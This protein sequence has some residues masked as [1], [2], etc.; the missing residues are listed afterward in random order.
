MTSGH[1]LTTERGLS[2]YLTSQSIAYTSVTLLTGGTANYVYRVILPSGSTT[3]YKHA[4]PYLPSNKAFAFDPNRMDY[5]DFVLEILPSLLQEQIPYSSVHA[6]RCN[7]YDPEIKLLCIEDGGYK[8]LKDA[9]TDLRL[10]IQKVGKDLGHWIAAVHTRSTQ[11]SL[12]LSDASDLKANNPTGVTI[13]RHSYRNLAT[14]FSQYGHDVSLA[15][16][17]D[18]EFGSRLA[19]EN[20]CICHGDFWPGNVLVK[21]KNE[22]DEQVDLTIV[23]WEMTRRGISATDVAQFCAEAFLLDRFRGGRELLPTFLNAYLVARQGSVDGSG[24]RIGKEW[25]RRLAVHW[26][27]HV[28]FWPTIVQWTDREGTQMLVDIGARVLRAVVDGDWETMFASA[29]LKGVDERFR[30]EMLRQGSGDVL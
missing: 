3:I 20:E 24:S 22:D 7:F 11:T 25:I 29:L 1:N 14:A 19:T 9:Y 23:D 18:T 27:V 28:A 5:E 8:M 2:A 16:Y 12:S 10:D 4:A 17:I 15:E 21:F 26:A 6:V 30:V 13:Y